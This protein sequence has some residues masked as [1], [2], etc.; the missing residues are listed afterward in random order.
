VKYCKNTCAKVI[1][2][3]DPVLCEICIDY[4]VQLLEKSTGIV[5]PNEIIRELQRIGNEL[6]KFHK[7]HY[8]GYLNGL[9]CGDYEEAITELRSYFDYS[10]SNTELAP[11]QYTALN[12][13]ALYMALDFP[14]QAF[15]V[16][17]C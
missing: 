3:F 11:I 6:S 7:H 14:K 17:F 10:I 4:Q 15:A 1:S 2:E 12:M 9:M 16:L 8:L 5:P 13:A